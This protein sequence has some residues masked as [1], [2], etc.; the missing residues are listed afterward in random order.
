MSAVGAMVA[1]Y[2]TLT[3]VNKRVVGAYFSPRI[4]GSSMVKRIVRTVQHVLP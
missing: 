3:E 2:P 4:F 1:P